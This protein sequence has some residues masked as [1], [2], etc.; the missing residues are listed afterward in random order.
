MNTYKIRPTEV[1]L[2]EDSPTDARLTR[3]SLKNAPSPVNVKLIESGREA[4]AYLRREPPFEKAKAPDLILLDLNLPGLDG[5]DLLRHMKADR[6]LGKIPVII[7]TSSMARSDVN[8]A[9]ELGANCYLT[10]PIHLDE[11]D[12]LIG[13]VGQ[14]WLRAAELP[15]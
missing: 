7:L 3:E 14:F 5:R 6:Q 4:L 10:K 8:T 1:L 12:D 9:Y 11:Y 2:V 15:A 13:L